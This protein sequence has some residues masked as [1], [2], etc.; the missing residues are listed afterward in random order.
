MNE[1]KDLASTAPRVTLLPGKSKLFY[2]RHPWVFPG[3]IG[4]AEAA[5]PDGSV[6]QLVSHNGNFVAWGLFNSKSRVRVRLHSWEK[7][8][9][10]G[11]SLWRDRIRAAIR[12]RR[13]LG[14][15]DPDGACR[16]V[17]SEGDHLSGLVID[18]FGH[19]LSVQ[20][21][22]LGINQRMEEILD[23]LMDETGC[24]GI[25]RRQDKEMAKLEGMDSVEGLC[26]GKSPPDRV[27]FH[28]QG[29]RIG[30][31]LV[32]GQKT[33]YYLDQRDNRLF[34]GTLAKGRSVLDAFTYAGGFALRAALGGARSIVAIDQ[35]QNALDMAEAN[36]QANGMARSI[37]F[38]K[39]EVF[40]NLAQR[41][42]A[43]EKFGLVIVDPPKFARGKNRVQEALRGYRRLFTLAF[44]L[45]EEDGRLVLCSCTGSVTRDMLLD[46][47]SQVAAEERKYAR[48]LRISGAA[49]DHPVA[50]SCPESDYL[51]CFVLAVS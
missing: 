18:R 2:A 4:H 37:V 15:M 1:P 50:T 3:A 25:I 45:T 46:L 32:E 22:S 19:W 36:A 7:E 6:V 34:A 47:V 24:Q 40:E 39:A 38:Q 9:P 30:V 10:P 27:Q 14:L 44:R 28:E 8:S 17:N 21:S 48:I 12:L 51:K 49:P 29:L 23:I 41:V 13:D 31:N 42:D 43:G 33:G 20:T 35:S 26:R 16:I 5:I 11:P